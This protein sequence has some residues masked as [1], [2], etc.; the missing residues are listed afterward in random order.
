VKRQDYHLETYSNQIPMKKLFLV[1]ALA[2][3]QAS[4][5][6]VVNADN[7][8]LQPLISR[9]AG[10]FKSCG[11]RV[12]AMVASGSK[13]ES[14]DF[15]VNV[16][17]EPLGS[18]LKA[19][20]HSVTLRPGQTPS[21]T[22]IVARPAPVGFWIATADQPVPLTMTHAMP[23]DTPGFVMGVGDFTEGAKV[24]LRAVNGEQMQ[25]VV[26]YKN[27]PAVERIVSFAQTMGEPDISTMN[28]CLQGLMVRM[29]E[30]AKK[31]RD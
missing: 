27:D 4:A 19:G 14:Y 18:L 1:A 13:V 2:T 21:F 31:S 22:S 11:V 3:A 25:F 26:R 29:S 7:V 12:A 23:S 10:G 15:S 28:S 8:G 16:Q 9:D 6:T 17:I 5:Q 24:L 30:L 20:K